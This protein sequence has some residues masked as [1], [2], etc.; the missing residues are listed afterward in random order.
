MGWYKAAVSAERQAVL[1][2]QFFELFTK[3]HTPA[4]MAMFGVLQ[5]EEPRGVFFHLPPGNIADEMVRLASAQPCPRPDR[6][7][8]L[9]AGHNA[10]GD[11]YRRGEL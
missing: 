9:L 11:S 3:A 8:E 4:D 5:T 7:L 10:A 6:E 2:E 1:Q